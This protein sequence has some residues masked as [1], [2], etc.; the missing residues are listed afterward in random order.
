MKLELK[1]QH[2]QGASNRTSLY[3]V[4]IPEPHNG[5][6]IIFSHGYMGFKDWGCW[7]L[8]SDFFTQAGYGFCKYNVSHNGGNLNQPID[9]PDLEAFAANSYTKELYDS[10]QVIAEIKK[11]YAPRNIFLI[12]H[13]RGGG[14]MLLHSQNSA[15]AGIISWAGISSIE[16]RFPVGEELKA[17]EETGVRYGVNMRTK[18]K[19]PHDFSQ[20]LDFIEHKDS[21]S[22]EAAL[23]NRT[24]PVLIVHGELDTAVPLSEG[25]QLALWSKTELATIPETTHTFDASHPWTA[26]ELPAAL[27]RV[28]QETLT[29]I[30][31]HE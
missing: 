31:H 12:G 10:Q 7:Q 27:Q 29:F 16:A 19:M 5:N 21:L 26:T 8:V 11:N 4:S 22:I 17:W 28:C 20:Y 3:D 13:S 2:Y 6:F 18:Q 25:Q 15:L 1:N 9:F 30:Q 14:I 24:L 23:V